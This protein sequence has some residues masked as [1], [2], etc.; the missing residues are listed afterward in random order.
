MDFNFMT[1]LIYHRIK[2]KMLPDLKMS[3]ILTHIIF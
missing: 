3:S 2:K 1:E